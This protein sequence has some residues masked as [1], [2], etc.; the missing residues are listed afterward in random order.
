MNWTFCLGSTF[1]NKSLLLNKVNSILLSKKWMCMDRFIH[2]TKG[3]SMAEIFIVMV[4]PVVSKITHVIRMIS[5]LIHPCSRWPLL[6]FKD[7]FRTRKRAISPSNHFIV[8]IHICSTYVR[9]IRSPLEILYISRSQIWSWYAFVDFIPLFWS[10][11]LF[12]HKRKDAF[13][14]GV[15]WKEWAVRTHNLPLGSIVTKS[16]QHHYR[17]AYHKITVFD[18]CL[19]GKYIFYCGIAITKP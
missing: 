2:G 18:W 14:V 12:Y 10:S 3:R 11:F 15:R 6:E 19:I 9:S 4:R 7:R 16:V 5:M 13:L 8:F 1:T 17:L